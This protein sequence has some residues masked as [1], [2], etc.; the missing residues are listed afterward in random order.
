MVRKTRK[1][2]RSVDQIEL[3]VSRE[4]AENVYTRAVR[5]D[6]FGNLLP[7]LSFI[8]HSCL[9]VVPL[10]QQRTMCTAH[11][12][13]TRPDLRN[14]IRITVNSPASP[15]RCERGKDQPGSGKRRRRPSHV[16]HVETSGQTPHKDGAY[17]HVQRK[18]DEMPHSPEAWM[19]R[20]TFQSCVLYPGTTLKR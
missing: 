7:H 3:G 17:A 5:V 16:P 2:Q 4:A 13:T 1:G 15:S 10:F 12:H 6:L 18:S 11:G 8:S 19:R 14:Q 20:Y 9:S